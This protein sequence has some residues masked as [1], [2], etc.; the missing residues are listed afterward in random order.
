MEAAQA[1]A[2]ELSPPLSVQTAHALSMICFAFVGT[3]VPLADCVAAD[4]LA[5]LELP[6]EPLAG[7]LPAGGP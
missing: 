3:M 1:Q 6:E 2:L 7:L 4:V 5:P